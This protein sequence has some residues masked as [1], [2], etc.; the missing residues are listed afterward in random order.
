VTDRDMPPKGEQELPHRRRVRRFSE[1]VHKID[2]LPPGEAARVRAKVRAELEAQ[3]SEPPPFDGEDPDFLRLMN[4][5][6]ESVPSVDDHGPTHPGDKEGQAG[7]DEEEHQQGQV[8]GAESH[9]E[10]A[11]QGD[12]GGEHV[13]DQGDHGG[14]IPPS[15]SSEPPKLV[16]D[17]VPRVIIE[18]GAQPIIRQV[19][20]NELGFHLAAKLIEELNEL[21]NAGP[22]TELEELADLEEVVR[23]M[24]TNRGYFWSEVEEARKAKRA[25]RGGFDLGLVWMGN[26]P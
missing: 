10:Q 4:A 26:E 8:Q 15:G 23:A 3:L 18:S 22:A 11:E 6:E 2:D 14:F 5:A 20:G 25:S 21:W 9:P 1:L 13:A 17:L 16:R 24:A 19:V 7:G 12:Q